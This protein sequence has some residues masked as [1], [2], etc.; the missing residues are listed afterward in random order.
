MKHARRCPP[1]SAPALAPAATA[2][3]LLKQLCLPPSWLPPCLFVNPACPPPT[4]KPLHTHG[5]SCVV[6]ATD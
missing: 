1:C 6:C 4:F 5:T 2:G 3:T